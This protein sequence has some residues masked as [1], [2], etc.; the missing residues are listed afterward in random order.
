MQYDTRAGDS[1]RI[2][3]E[4][5]NSLLIE[6]RHI[7]SVLPKTNLSLFG[8]EFATPVMTAAF[9]HL[10]RMHK[11]GLVEMARGA[12]AANAVMWIGMG[13]DDELSRVT[14]VGAKTIRITK[15]YINNDDIFHDIE[16]AEKCGC[17]AVGIDPDHSYNSK[18]GNDVIG[19]L[20]MT[21][22]TL[23]EIKQFVSATK[24]PFIIKGVLS[25]QD[26][27]KC[28]EAGVKG[29]VVSHHSGIMDYAVPPLMILPEIV[30]AVN[31]KMKIFVDCGVDT[32]YDTFKALA[33]GA[34]AV[35]L[36]RAVL[37]TFSKN[38]ANGVSDMI[39]EM[40]AQL[41]GVMAKTCSPD[42]TKIDSSLIRRLT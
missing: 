19:D 18:G 9:S 12:K 10:D 21:G 3:R 6:M 16:H 35:C 42:I 28:M 32:G 26:A 25:V 41:A 1:K 38:G 39:N 20:V 13:E 7:D 27:L 17:I 29:I 33:L 34:D 5:F 23:A 2:T 31:G 37:D 14:D 24:L 15:P 8:E 22:K 4:F 11:D 30:K 40:T 36:G